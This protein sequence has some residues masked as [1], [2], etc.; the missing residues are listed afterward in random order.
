MSHFWPRVLTS[1]PYVPG[2]AVATHLEVP[3]KPDIHTFHNNYLTID[4]PDGRVYKSTG[5][6][7]TQHPEKAGDPKQRFKHLREKIATRNLQSQENLTDLIAKCAYSKNP[8][9]GAHAIFN[10]KEIEQT[11][12]NNDDDNSGTVWTIH[13]LLSD[14][15]TQSSNSYSPYAS[16]LIPTERFFDYTALKI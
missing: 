8:N 1:Y 16:A 15:A 9:I 6:G 3:R 14:D 11:T 5:T 2:Q 4:T 10:G 12:E 7:T 13:P